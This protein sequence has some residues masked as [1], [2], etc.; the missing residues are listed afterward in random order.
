MLSL[1]KRNYCKCFLCQ[2]ADMIQ[3]Y[4]IPIMGLARNVFLPKPTQA[5]KKVHSHAK[6]LVPVL[7]MRRAYSELDRKSSQIGDFGLPWQSRRE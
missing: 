2:G 7:Q 6:Y 3:I 5:L 1:K 4:P